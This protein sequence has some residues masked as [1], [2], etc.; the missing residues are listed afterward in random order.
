MEIHIND[1][2]II[3]HCSYDFTKSMIITY[4]QNNIGKSYSMQTIYIVLRTFAEESLRRTRY[5][6]YTYSNSHR[7]Q[8]TILD[9]IKSDRYEWD[10]TSKVIEER[11]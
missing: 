2:G 3:E 6:D 8:N 5:V 4:G 10:I 9:F 1:F 7:L 11:D